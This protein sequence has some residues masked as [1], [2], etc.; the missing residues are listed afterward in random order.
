[1]SYARGLAEGRTS[2]CGRAM[3]LR[4]TFGD[5][6]ECAA[7]GS[8]EDEANEGRWAMRGKRTVATSAAC[9]SCCI[10]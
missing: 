5:A 1:M 9:C 6:V 10:D 3:L 4:S 7:W 8:L 2:E